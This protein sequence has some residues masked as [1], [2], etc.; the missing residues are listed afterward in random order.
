MPNI[1]IIM[2]ATSHLELYTEL[3]IKTWQKYC[4]SFGYRF[5]HYD[6]AYFDDLHLV[7]SKIKSVEEHLANSNADYV[8]LVDADTIPTSF[9]LSIE[10]IIEKNMIGQKEILFQKDGSDRLKYLFFTHNLPIT[11]KSK[12]WVLPNAGFIIQKNTPK[13]K[14]FYEEWLKLAHTS[15][16]AN[17]PPRN[18]RVLIFEMLVQ[19]KYDQMIG[20]LS[21]SIINKYKGDLAIHFSSMNAQQIRDNM[22]PFYNKLVK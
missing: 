17:V 11:L 3:S 7:W 5:F 1:D 13:V 2:F 22:L 12:R 6:K 18:Q 10:S 20:F 19:K 21:T 14:G 8:V 4:E 9:D 16:L 15:P